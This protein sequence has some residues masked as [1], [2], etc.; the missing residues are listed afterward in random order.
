MH[1]RYCILNFWKNKAPG[2]PHRLLR[3][4]RSEGLIGFQATARL[5]LVEDDFDW[6]SRQANQGQHPI[7]DLVEAGS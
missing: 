7:K 1:C 3:R 2:E 6:G 4:W 5:R